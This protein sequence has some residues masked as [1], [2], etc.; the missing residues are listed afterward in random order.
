[1]EEEIDCFTFALKDTTQPSSQA[2]T[3]APDYLDH[4]FVKVEQMYGMLESHMQHSSTQF[5]YI[6]S[7][8][9]ALSSQIDDMMRDQQLQEDSDSESTQ[10]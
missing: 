5:T 2:R 1:M 10:F 4:I 8:I 9:T 6:E 7:Q 3:W